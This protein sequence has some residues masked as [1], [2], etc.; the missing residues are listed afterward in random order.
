MT[1]KIKHIPA[2]LFGTNA[3]YEV[4]RYFAVLPPDITFEDLFQPATWA[5]FG[6]PPEDDGNRFKPWDIV[7]VVSENGEFDVD[8]TVMDVQVGAVRMKV[9]PFF[10]DASAELALQ[11]A[12]RVAETNPAVI[13]LMADGLP[14]VRVEH[15]P[16]TG[17]RVLGMDGEVSRDHKTEAHAVKAMEKYVKAAGLKM[18]EAA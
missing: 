6:G 7:R 11:E 2:K 3:D 5:H 13:P 16:A 8:L 15:L 12:N 1:T 4:G 17:W 18:P 14:K 9:R 10:R